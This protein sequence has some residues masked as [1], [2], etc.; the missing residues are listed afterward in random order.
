MT[1]EIDVDN[2][3]LEALQGFVDPQLF[4]VRL[5]PQQSTVT[6][7]SQRR[8]HSCVETLHSRLVSRW[9]AQSASL[10]SLSPHS[11][12]YTTSCAANESKVDSVAPASP[13]IRTVYCARG[14]HMQNLRN[15]IGKDFKS[16]KVWQLSSLHECFTITKQS[17]A[18]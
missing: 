16:E 7:R 4:F 6:Y 11:N 17:H 9:A 18:V 5:P 12:M 3:G 1:Q 2:L 15:P 10:D 13:E 8:F 14:Q